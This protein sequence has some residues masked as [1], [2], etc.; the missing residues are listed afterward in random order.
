MQNSKLDVKYVNDNNGK[1]TCEG[2]R[3]E[4]SQSR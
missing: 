2:K 4:N 3:E 1:D